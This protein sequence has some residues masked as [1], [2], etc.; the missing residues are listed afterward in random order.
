MTI[1]RSGFFAKLR[2]GERSDTAVREITGVYVSEPSFPGFRGFIQLL[3]GGESPTTWVGANQHPRTMYFDGGQLPDIRAAADYLKDILAEHVAAPA[4]FAAAIGVDE[5]ANPVAPIVQ[6]PESTAA[7]TQIAEPRQRD[8]VILMM[9]A[10]PVLIREAE[11]DE[12]HDELQH[13]LD[14]DIEE[15]TVREELRR[16]PMGRGFRL[17]PRPAHLV[18]DLTND[19]LETTPTIL[20][21]SGHGL[22]AGIVMEDGDRQPVIVNPEAL[23]LLFQ[24]PVI[25][26]N[27]R[28]VVLNACL[29]A[30]QAKFLAKHVDA[31]IGTTDPISD[32]AA[33]AFSRQLYNGLG[34]G[35]SIADAYQTAVAQVAALGGEEAGLLVLAHR[36]GVDP[37]DL[38]P[39][40]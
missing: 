27:L 33:I 5:H 38:K 29:S 26:E 16:T 14:L 12:D 28:L 1:E 6:T 37:R 3:V 15:R 9:T 31:V 24:V 40:A 35:L 4:P 20:H 21:F 8:K 39:L 36:P 25:A 18:A 13:P 10:N 17:E 30:T 22:V 2:Q 34:F 23:A 19:L 32:P 7:I 11:D